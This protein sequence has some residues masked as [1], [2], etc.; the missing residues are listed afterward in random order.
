MKK[1]KST[2]RDAS[3]VPQIT[4]YHHLILIALFIL[5]DLRNSTIRKDDEYYENLLVAISHLWHNT[6]IPFTDFPL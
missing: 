3:A 1:G 2:Y 4:D 5:L 6:C